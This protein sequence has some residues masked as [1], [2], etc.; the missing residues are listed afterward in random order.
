MGEGEE[1]KRL[2]YL[3]LAK[4]ISRTE[5]DYFVARLSFSKCGSPILMR[6]L[7]FL[8]IMAGTRFMVST[9]ALGRRCSFRELA[10][11]VVVVVSIIYTKDDDDDDNNANPINSSRKKC[12]NFKCP[13]CLYVY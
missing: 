4:G 12:L 3:S 7:W 6:G 2:N 5:R 8:I 1:E 13:L 10:N 11:F 9:T